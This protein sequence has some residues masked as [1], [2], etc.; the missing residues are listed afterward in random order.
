MDSNIKRAYENKQVTGSLRGISGFLHNRKYKNK[1]DVANIIKKLDS[2]S[3]FKP[4]RVNF[5]SRRMIVTNSNEWF[6]ADLAAFPSKQKYYNAHYNYIL[7]FVDCFS[8]MTYLRALK[9]KSAEEVS[10][11]LDS[12]LKQLRLKLPSFLMTDRGLEFKNSHVAAIL[13][14]YNVKLYFSFTP[15]KAFIAE[16]KIR[17]IKR[18]LERYYYVTGKKEWRSFLP[19]LESSLNSSYHRS[20]KMTPNEARKPIN[21]G[22]VFE[23]LYSDLFMKPIKRPTFKVGDSVRISNLRKSHIFQKKYKESFSRE[24]Y[25]IHEIKHTL[26]VVS[27]TLSDQKGNIIQGSYV[28]VELQKYE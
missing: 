8:K 25:K 17:F 11:A 26:P 24:V 28:E 18:I 4:H 19:S 2:Y 15:K 12:I 14:K 3:L 9:K 7:V 23:N 13:K 21:Q 5:Q 20:I 16:N 27:Y 1:A 6:Q 22:Q 10:K